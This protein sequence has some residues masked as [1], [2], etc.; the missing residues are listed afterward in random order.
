[1][2]THARC[3]RGSCMTGCV[4]AGAS[5]LVALALTAGLAAAT[6]AYPMVIKFSFDSLLNG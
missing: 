5:L 3:F 4:R 6:G 2:R 1:M